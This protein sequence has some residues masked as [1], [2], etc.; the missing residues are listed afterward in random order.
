MTS[1]PDG[2]IPTAY[3]VPADRYRCFGGPPLASQPS[4]SC[5]ISNLNLSGPRGA[6]Q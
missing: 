5:Q 3:K 6:L 2:N 1:R 4:S